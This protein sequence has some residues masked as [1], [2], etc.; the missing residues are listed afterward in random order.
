MK[1]TKAVAAAVAGSFVFALPSLVRLALSPSWQAWLDAHMTISV[2]TARNAY[3]VLIPL[4]IFWATYQT[5]KEENDARVKAETDPRIIDPQNK[6]QSLTA[7]QRETLVET[8]KPY[9]NGT[10]SLFLTWPVF[11]NDIPDCKTLA[12]DIAYVLADSKW[13]ILAAVD[14]KFW[15]PP[16]ITI[17]AGTQDQKADALIQALQD[18]LG[19]KIERRPGSP[20]IIIGC[21]VPQ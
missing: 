14:T 18:I 17:M 15:S 8:L 10:Q 7:E 16:G 12:A 11:A 9:G 1:H 4:G 6:W 3:M 13:T 5:W 21:Y 20:R 2:Y 19:V